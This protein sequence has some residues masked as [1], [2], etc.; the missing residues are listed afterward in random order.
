MNIAN[1]YSQEWTK[2]GENGKG[3]FNC[4]I[5][6]ITE[7]NR[8]DGE[9]IVELEDG[10]VTAYLRSDLQNLILSYAITVHKSQGCE[11]DAVII[12]VVSGAYMILT[13]N[14]LYTAVTRAKRL[15]VLV[16]TKENIQ[17]MVN[18]TYT[19]KRHSA[20][21]KFLQYDDMTNFEL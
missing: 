6:T 1:N 3:I 7:I 12:P 15:V 2:D 19:K 18:N 16:G 13:R 10:R 20:L 8:G 4:D 11:F 17:K 14:L 9:I 5:G 21:A